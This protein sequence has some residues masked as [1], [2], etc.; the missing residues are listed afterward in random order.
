MRVRIIIGSADGGAMGI[1]RSLFGSNTP[2]PVPVRETL[3]GDLPIDLW[4]EGAADS[5]PW[6]AFASAR[7]EAAQGRSD[8]AVRGW[9]EV[10]SRPGLESRH[11]LQAWHFLRQHGQHPPPEA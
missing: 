7:A 2:A 4:P 11:Y 5:F 6:T 8:A 1:F 10:L 3:F 9:C